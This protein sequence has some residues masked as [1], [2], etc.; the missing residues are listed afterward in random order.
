MNLKPLTDVGESRL[1]R[2]PVLMGV[3]LL[4]AC[5]LAAPT[6]ATWSV[7]AVDT[8]TL[9][10]AIASATCVTGIDLKAFS[11]A[12]VVAKGGGAAQSLVDGSG[13]RRQI[14]RDGFVAGTS[15]DD[16]MTQLIAQ[17]GSSNHQNGVA[18]QLGDSATFSGAVTGAHSS[19]AIGNFGTVHYAVQGNILTGRPVVDMAE[20]ALDQH[21]G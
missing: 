13:A 1:D 15:A 2:G 14:M 4:I 16:I 9:E 21:G 17:S 11:P 12:L 20:S 6:W 8:E 7:V 5:F 18:T 19:G 3:V 10:V